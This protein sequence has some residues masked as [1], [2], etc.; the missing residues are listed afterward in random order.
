MM[1]SAALSLKKETGSSVVLVFI[2]STDDWGFWKGCASKKDLVILTQKAATIN[3]LERYKGDLRAIVKLPEVR[4]ARI[5]QIKLSA[6]MC[7]TEGVITASDRVVCMTGLSAKGS[8]DTLMCLDLENETEIFSTAGVSKE[9]LSKVKPEVIE[10]VLGI[11]LELSS[12]GREGRT[13]GATFVI[14][15]HENVVK[16]SRPLIMNPFKGY[17]EDARNILDDAV[18]ETIKEFALLDG[19]FVVR[20]DGVVVSA[21][22]HL[23]AAL[24]EE[25]HMPGLGCRHM[26]AAGITDVT[27]ATAVTISGSTGIVRIFR[28]GKVLFEIEKG[29][30]AARGL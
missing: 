28:K 16:L 20:E 13:I 27:D 17:P 29:P 12:E 15:D 1:L 9:L 22:V 21:G 10:T 6:I 8:M 2:D 18:H 7:M 11:A 19:A 25:G 23:D 14:G 5:G 3:D 26:A 4:L 30:R 24:E